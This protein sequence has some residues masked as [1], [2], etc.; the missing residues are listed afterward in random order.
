[1]L[2]SIYTIC[3]VDTCNNDKFTFKFSVN[4]YKS[5]KAGESRYDLLNVG[6]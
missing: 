6:R 3:N 1:M 4:K 2:V 5:I